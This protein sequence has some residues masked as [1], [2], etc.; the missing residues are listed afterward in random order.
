MGMAFFTQIANPSF[1]FSKRASSSSRSQTPT[2]TK[3]PKLDKSSSKLST[4]S[5]SS[6]VTTVKIMFTG[7]PDGKEKK[8]VFKNHSCLLTNFF[9]QLESIAKSL[10][11]T[12]VD[13]WKQATHLIAPSMKRTVKFLCSVSAGK[14]VVSDKWLVE[15][16][17]E[18]G[19][20]GNLDFY[21]N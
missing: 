5:S 14:F 17:K 10:G 2:A 3:K 16:K 11:G 6:A 12:I 7:I 19:F 8:N 1:K 18:S 15:S 20:I 9:Y 13:S 4:V 21:F